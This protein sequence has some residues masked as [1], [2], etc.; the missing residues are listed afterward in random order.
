[1]DKPVQKIIYT[2]GVCN[3][4]PAEIAMRKRAGWIG[5]AVTVLTWFALEHFGANPYWRLLLVLPAS[6]A[7]TVWCWSLRVMPKDTRSLN[8]PRK[9]V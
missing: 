1:M 5:L 3:I 6:M 2:P 8:M 9:A 4:G 7:A